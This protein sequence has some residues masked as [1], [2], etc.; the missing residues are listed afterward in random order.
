MDKVVLASDNSALQW[1]HPTSG[2]STPTKVLHTQGNS[3]FFRLFNEDPTKSD[4]AP[5]PWCQAKLSWESGHSAIY[6]N[7]LGC[8][9]Y[10][11]KL[12]YP[13]TSNSS[14]WH[15]GGFLPFCNNVAN[16]DISD[17]TIDGIEQCVCEVEKLTDPHSRIDEDGTFTDET[18]EDENTKVDD[19]P[20]PE[21]PS[22]SI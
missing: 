1:Y 15:S 19:F 8:L 2:G 5:T 10:K 16:R 18:A 7:K 20:R 14:C 12:D 13:G 6:L 4:L 22:A 11:P 21:S 9:T 17:I 3:A